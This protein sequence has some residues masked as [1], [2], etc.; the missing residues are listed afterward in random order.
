[1][2]PLAIVDELLQGLLQI[3]EYAFSVPE[4]WAWLIVILACSSCAEIVE[5]LQHRRPPAKDTG[6]KQE[7]Q[8]VNDVASHLSLRFLFIFF[9]SLFR[10]DGNL[11]VVSAE[12]SARITG[13]VEHDEVGVF[14]HSLLLCITLFIV[15]FQGESYDSLILLFHLSQSCCDVMGRHQCQLQVILSRLIFLSA[16][17]AGRK[18]ATAAQRMA[19]S[20]EAKAA[21]AA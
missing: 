15:G 16:T 13:R 10:D 1:M 6:L 7:S 5:G 8:L 14:L 18:S 4:I 21:V 9:L 20:D 3:V 11:I 19:A 2:S 12:S 17:L